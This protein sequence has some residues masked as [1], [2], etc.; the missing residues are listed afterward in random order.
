M[1][2]WGQTSFNFNQI[3]IIYDENYLHTK[4]CFEMWSYYDADNI[5]QLLNYKAFTIISFLHYTMNL[6]KIA[7]HVKLSYFFGRF[8]ATLFELSGLV[9][10]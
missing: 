6:P 4:W 8:E 2:T 10:M 9:I 5:N 3:V 1:V 7:T